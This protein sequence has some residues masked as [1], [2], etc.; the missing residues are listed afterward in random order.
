MGYHSGLQ[1]ETAGR[2]T[3]VVHCIQ[4]SLAQH[5]SGMHDEMMMTM[6]VEVKPTRAPVRSPSPAYQ[7]P[8]F[9]RLDAL[10]T[11][12]PNRV[13]ALKTNKT[14]TATA[15]TTTKQQQLASTTTTTTFS[16]CL[17]ALFYWIIPD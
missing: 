1:H 17:T 7:Q 2:G 6:Q 8:V 12:Q 3:G 5:H 9:Y 14:T 13:K 16:L 15:T 11:T 4:Q 10:P